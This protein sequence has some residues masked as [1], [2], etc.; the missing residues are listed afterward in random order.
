MCRQCF[1]MKTNMRS[2]NLPLDYGFTTTHV[3]YPELK[4]K[5]AIFKVGDKI[6]A[7]SDCSGMIKGSIYT[8]TRNGENLKGV[9]C[10]CPEKW[11]LVNNNNKTI[12]SKLKTLF[13]RLVDHDVQVLSEV[14]F[15]NGDLALTQ[16]GKDEIMNLL[17]LEKKA[18]LVKVAQEMLDEAKKEKECK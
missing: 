17:F 10:S 7:L 13:K 9:N 6:R 1:D 8:V 11:E 3:P 2:Y 15:L 16:E 14:G 4:T 5:M 18:E 12:M